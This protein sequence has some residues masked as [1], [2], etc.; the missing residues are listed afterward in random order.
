[1]KKIMI[2]CI[3]SIL[4]ILLISACKPQ[5]VKI[6]PD[7]VT[8]QLKWVHQAQFA[9]IYMAQDK[10]Y[11]AEENLKVNFLEAG[12]NTDLIE[13][14]TNGKAD[15]AVTSPEEL[16]VKRSQGYPVTAIAAIYRRSAVVFV[17]KADS[18]IINPAGFINKT[19]SVS[20]YRDFEIQFYSM[21]EKL[22]LDISMV[23]LV[24][25]D[26]DYT[27][28]YNGDVD[29]TPAYLTAG[30]IKIEQKGYKLNIIWPGDY[31]VHFYSDI[32]VCSDNLI[33]SNPDLT[34]RF[35]KATLKGWQDAIGNEEATITVIMKYAKVQ[36]LKLQSEMMEAQ[37]PL[38]H[39]GEDQIGW[40][41]GEQWKDM[42]RVLAEYG[43]IAMPFDFTKLY[44]MQFL[45]K[46]YGGK[47]K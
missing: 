33:V 17:S 10:G 5:E 28:F 36:D 32:L 30:V 44:D 26:P 21:M 1:M 40:M 6:P 41:K 46:I 14:L 47:N 3:S 31:G 24:P 42:Y 22:G 4:L 27:G 45:E 7:K 23:K 29:V 39:T 35:L 13:Q 18:G 25:Y 20:E 19:V 2:F 9:G 15:F 11:Y 8:V 34:E 16:I 12:L 37:I 38:V 43:L